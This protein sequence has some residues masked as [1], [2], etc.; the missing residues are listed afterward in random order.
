MTWKEYEKKWPKEIEMA[1]RGLNTAISRGIFV[2]LL[3]HD[4]Q[5]FSELSK[6]LEIKPNKLSY[7]LKNLVKNG[8]LSHTYAHEEQRQDHSFYEASN[9]GNIYAKKCLE[10]AYQPYQSLVSPTMAIPA[11]DSEK[12]INTFKISSSV[13]SDDPPAIY[14]SEKTPKEEVEKEL[15]VTNPDYITSEE[16]TKVLIIK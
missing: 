7:H 16:T 12:S 8:L 11:P 1:Q 2:Y 13:T 6:N 5:T 15:S 9:F 4:Q 10:A 3:T 14:L